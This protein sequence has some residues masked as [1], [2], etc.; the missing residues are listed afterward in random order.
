MPPPLCERRRR[1]KQRCSQTQ[2]TKLRCYDATR[3]PNEE[4]QVL[5]RR[6]GIPLRPADIT[7]GERS[8]KELSARFAYIER[9]SKFD[10]AK[11]T[12]ELRCTS[13]R[14]ED[15]SSA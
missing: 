12:R 10:I 5:L 14:D 1:S 8:V 6:L 7:G 9:R 3:Y 4:T 11:D 15:R 2:A 13:S